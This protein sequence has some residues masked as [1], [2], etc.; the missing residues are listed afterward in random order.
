MEHFAA[1]QQNV[2]A[3]QQDVAD[4]KRENANLQQVVADSKRGNANLQQNFIF[5]K[6]MA[7]TMVTAIGLHIFYYRIIK[8]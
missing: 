4:Y 5:W 7:L 8:G 6:R 1:L 2:S 3:L